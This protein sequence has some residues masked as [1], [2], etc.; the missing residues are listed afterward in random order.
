MG[1]KEQDWKKMK[2]NGIKFNLL[3][4]DQDFRKIESLNF[5]PNN[6]DNIVKD[7]GKRYGIEK[8]NPDESKEIKTEMDFLKKAN[9]I[10]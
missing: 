5:N 7:V 1:Y 2:M 6:F 8:N 9:L 10:R 4:R 3:V